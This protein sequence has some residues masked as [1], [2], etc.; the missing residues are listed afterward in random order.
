MSAYSNHYGSGPY[1]QPEQPYQY[2]QYMQAAPQHTSM[3]QPS[4]TTHWAQN[5]YSQPQQQPIGVSSQSPLGYNAVGANPPQGPNYGPGSVGQLIQ[6]P[7][8]YMA[9]PPIGSAPAFPWPASAPFSPQQPAVNSS[10]LLQPGPTHPDTP[11]TPHPP[12][13]ASY[14][15][16]PGKGQSNTH[17]LP[18]KQPSPSQPSASRM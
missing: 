8:T 10:A 3:G 2:N 17:V 11:Y 15:T 16:L 14:G 7:S 18:P 13:Q 9:P 5:P 4:T 6:P 12:P 1:G